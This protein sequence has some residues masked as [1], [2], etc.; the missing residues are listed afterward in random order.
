MVNA[1]TEFSSSSGH[2][3]SNVTF[4]FILSS[5]HTVVVFMS[6]LP[7]PPV[8]IRLRGLIQKGHLL[9]WPSA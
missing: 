9:S 3:Q 5:R 1:Y 2:S 4:G 7:M 6:H 8:D